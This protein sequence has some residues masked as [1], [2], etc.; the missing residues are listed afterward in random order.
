[1][2]I[3]II[4]SILLC[5]VA[6]ASSTHTRTPPPEAPSPIWCGPMFSAGTQTLNPTTLDC[7]GRVFAAGRK[8]YVGAYCR[9]RTPVRVLVWLADDGQVDLQSY[10]DVCFDHDD[11][12]A[13]PPPDMSTPPDMTTT[14]V[15][16]KG[17]K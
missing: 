6:V 12:G 5:G 1:M 13:P 14:K 15:K 2:K 16:K 9:D 17:A 11:G 8:A 7:M 3:A 4:A 10:D